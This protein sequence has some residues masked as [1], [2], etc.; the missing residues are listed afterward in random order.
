HPPRTNQQMPHRLLIFSEIPRVADA[1]W[2]AVP[3]LDRL[4]EH[5]A[6]QGHFDRVLDVAHLDAVAGRPLPVDGNIQVAFTHDRLG[7]DVLAPRNRSQH[8]SDFLA[9]PIDGFQVRT[10]N[11]NAD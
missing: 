9:D 10:E 7:H 4:G 11:L 5:P 2:E 6:A 3:A 8:T 1:H